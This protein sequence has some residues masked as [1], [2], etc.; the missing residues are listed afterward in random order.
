ML[1]GRGCP[2][3][4]YYIAYTKYCH[5]DELYLSDA[6]MSNFAYNLIKVSQYRGKNII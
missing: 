2:P 5:F 3:A 4:Y 1:E 6:S